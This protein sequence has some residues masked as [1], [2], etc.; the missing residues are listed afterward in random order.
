LAD[1]RFCDILTGRNADN[2]GFTYMQKE[3]STTNEAAWNQGPYD[4]WTSR[5]GTPAEAAARI[6]SN[7]AARLSTLHTWIGD[8]S[9]KKV[10]NLLGSHG[11][12]AVAMAL[13]GAQA[14]VVDIASENARYA[15]ELAKA[16]GVE[17]NYIVSD[18]LELQDDVLTGD[19]QIVLMEFG[20]LHYFTDLLPLM[21][22]VS[23]L[24]SPGGRLV[25]QDFHP[26]TTK[27]ISSRGTTQAIRKHKVDGDYFD[28]SIEEVEVPYLKFLSADKQ[29]DLKKTKLRRWTLGEIVTSVATA[30]LFLEVLKEEPNLSSE[31]FD[32]GIPKTF[33]L[34]AKRLAYLLS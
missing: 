19:Y 25:L 31:L 2:G 3:V 11:S 34:V 28:T 14:T 15:K 13:L 32:K 7:P 21:T 20:I 22:I 26:I 27:L 23:R 29:K 30:G 33:T 16:A 1:G 17:L 6:A 5:Y 8:V 4:A 18:V 10:I 9:G 24:L 12:K